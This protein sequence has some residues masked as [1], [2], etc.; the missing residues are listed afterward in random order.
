MSGNITVWLLPSSWISQANERLVLQWDADENEDASPFVSPPYLLAW[1]FSRCMADKRSWELILDG[2][3]HRTRSIRIGHRAI[4][5]HH[6]APATDV[7][8]PR[9]ELIVHGCKS[10]L[11]LL[12]QFLCDRGVR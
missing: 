2:L 7:V 10:L 3:E 8:H 5:T 6:I 1:Q 11:E 4:L 9:Q 12:I